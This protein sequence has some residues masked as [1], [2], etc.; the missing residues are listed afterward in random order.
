MKGREHLGDTDV[1]GRK[2]NCIFYD[3][4]VKAWN[5]FIWFIKDGVFFGQL[6]DY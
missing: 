1:N 3:I 4:F 5:E 2:L 6:S